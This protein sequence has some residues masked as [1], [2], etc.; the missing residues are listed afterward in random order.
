MLFCVLSSKEN[1]VLLLTHN[2][3]TRMNRQQRPL[4]KLKE[5]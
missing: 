3:T 2:F 5:E 4:S 1:A